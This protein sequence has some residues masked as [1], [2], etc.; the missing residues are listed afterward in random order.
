MLKRTLNLPKILGIKNSAFLFGA[1]GVGKSTLVKDFLQMESQRGIATRTIDLLQTE[2]Y[3]RYLKHPE[4]LRRELEKAASLNQ[5]G[6]TV[7]IDEVQRVPALLNE[8]HGLMESDLKGLRFLLTG[9]SARKLKRQSANML[10]G[11]AFS[12]RLHPLTQVEWQ[13]EIEDRLLFGSLPGIAWKSSDSDD[14]RRHALR[15]YAST[16][17]REEIQ[18]EALVRR[19]DAFARFIEVA[20][21]FHTKTINASTLAKAS[22]VSVNT[23]SEYL[24]ILEDTLVAMKLPGWSAS[25]KKQLRTAPKLYFFD[26]GV[27]NALRGE[28]NSPVRES[29]GRYGELFEGTVIQE[30]CRANDYSELDLKFSYWRTNNDMEVDLI[31]SKG[32][33]K[34]IAAI[35][36]K[37]AVDPEHKD[38]RGLD[39]F[40]TEWPK[41]PQYCVC[42]AENGYTTEFGVEIIPWRQAPELLRKIAGK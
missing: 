38:L 41:V 28:L 25:V 34:P 12:L 21:Q 36:I 14:D 16:Y 27:V 13:Q 1:R 6:L 10:A 22:G 4:F 9:S 20:G 5:N 35:E 32:A 19:L 15:S 7:V 23:V 2:T 3:E 30:L 26:N 18:Q 11:R 42:R 33:G 31:L 17:L 37:S 24:Q 39:A 29:T 8:V 40:R